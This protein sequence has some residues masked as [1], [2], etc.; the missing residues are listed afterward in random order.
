MHIFELHITVQFYP[1]V[2]ITLRYTHLFG[3]SALIRRTHACV[4]WLFAVNCTI[5]TQIQPCRSSHSTRKLRVLSSVVSPMWGSGFVTKNFDDR[6]SLQSLCDP[7][8]STAPSL[9][10]GCSLAGYCVLS[11][12]IFWTPGLWTYQPGSH[13]REATQDFSTFLLLQCLP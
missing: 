1:A 10:P 11:P 3:P 12:H 7:P 2:L 6:L 8:A 9:V 4:V 13:R 5:P